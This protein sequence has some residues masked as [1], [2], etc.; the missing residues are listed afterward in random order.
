MDEE[1][2][3]RCVA[4]ITRFKLKVFG[5]L[6]RLCK[7]ARLHHLGHWLCSAIERATFLASSRIT[8][9]ANS[10]IAAVC[11]WFRTSLSMVEPFL[12]SASKE[13]LAAVVTRAGGEISSL[14]A[15][16]DFD[17]DVLEHAIKGENVVVARSV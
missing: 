10:L 3:D 11:K 4:E 16:S 14:I 12:W 6:F 7:R 8:L 13:A 15:A 9:A 2:C 1:L 17:D 5:Q